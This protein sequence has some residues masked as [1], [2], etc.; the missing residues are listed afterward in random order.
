MH[1]IFEKFK[2]YSGPVESCYSTDFLGIKTKTEYFTNN[3]YEAHH[4]DTPYP[5]FDE[6]YFEWIDVL[7]STFLANNSYTMIELGAG[8]GRWLSRAYAA[9]RQMRPE[10]VGEFI[11]VEAEPT[12]FKWLQEHCK[13]NHVIHT[14]LIEA[15]VD[16]NDGEV[17][18]YTGKP[19]EWYGQ[20][21]G[22]ETRVKAISLRSI[23]EPLSNVNLIDLDV[24]NFEFKILNSVQD[25][26]SR[27]QRVHIGTHSTRVERGLRIMFTK[28]GWKCVN[29]YALSTT[30]E[31]K[32]GTSK[33]NDGVQTWI[34]PKSED[35][36]Y[37]LE[38]QARTNRAGHLKGGCNDQEDDRDR[39]HG[40]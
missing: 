14:N 32:Y 12:H 4:E 15:A 23:L 38:S 24:Q 22:G 17:G 5:Q 31:T 13:Y 33:F 10:V 8:W 9:L 16:V 28:L 11:G 1:P 35:Y 20:C 7:E 34:N 6:E 36:A 19:A 40:G 37:Y 30:H 27:V 29:D 39:G 2:C 26:L 18:F 3:H 21:I 25:L